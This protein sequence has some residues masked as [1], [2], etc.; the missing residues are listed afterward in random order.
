MGFLDYKAR[1]R[2]MVVG[3]GYTYDRTALM[4]MSESFAGMEP[5]LVEHPRAEA[6]LNPEA[7]GDVDAVVL[8]D[9]PGGNPWTGP[10]HEVRPSERFQ[11]GF[12]ELLN[13]GVPIVALHHAIAAW[14]A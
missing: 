7:L 8:Y 11:R 13:A 5:F 14:T 6:A 1:P 3:N 4:A 9:M 2:I 10:G 12:L